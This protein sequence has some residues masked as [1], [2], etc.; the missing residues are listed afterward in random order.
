[1]H[2]LQLGIYI[3]LEVLQVVMVALPDGGVGLAVK[4]AAGLI[5]AIWWTS[6]PGADEARCVAG[7]VT[8]RIKRWLL[9]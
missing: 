3:V 1:M 5:G 6:G 8:L 7:D 4:V 2:A 9:A